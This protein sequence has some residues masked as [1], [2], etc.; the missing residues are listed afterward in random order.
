MPISNHDISVTQDGQ[1]SVSRWSSRDSSGRNISK[2]VF[3]IYHAVLYQNEQKIPIWE[4][5]YTAQHINNMIDTRMPIYIGNMMNQPLILTVQEDDGEEQE[6]DIRLGSR[7]QIVVRYDTTNV[8]EVHNSKGWWHWR[9]QP[10]RKEHIMTITIPELP[11]GATLS[12]DLLCYPLQ[13]ENGRTY[14]LHLPK[15]HKGDNCFYYRTDVQM[16]KQL[17]I[18]EDYRKFFQIDYEK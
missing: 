6:L 11:D 10:Q 16:G 3:R 12:E 18:R 14:L 13:F 7:Y 9:K 1:L 4:K 2:V 17:V 5:S 15:L 8:G